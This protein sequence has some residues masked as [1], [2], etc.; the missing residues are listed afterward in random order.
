[1]RSDGDEDE[2]AMFI[3]NLDAGVEGCME[4]CGKPITNQG[5]RESTWQSG[6]HSMAGGPQRQ[7]DHRS[8]CI[9]RMD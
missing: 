2:N 1:M 5:P 9:S 3:R 6:A 8:C 4:I 7:R